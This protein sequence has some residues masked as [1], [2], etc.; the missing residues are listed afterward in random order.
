MGRHHPGFKVVRQDSE[1]YGQADE[2]QDESDPGE[3]LDRVVVPETSCYCF[4]CRGGVPEEARDQSRVPIPPPELHRHLDERQVLVHRLD[5][6]LLHV[7]VVA[8]EVHPAGGVAGEGT[9]TC[10]GIPDRP[11]GH[12]TGHPGG[13]F[14]APDLPAGHVVEGVDLAVADDDI[15]L[16]VEDGPEE[17]RDLSSVVLEVGVGVD[18]DIRPEFYGGIQ[19]VPEGLCEPEVP[20]VGDDVV[21]A[22]VQC[23]FHRVVGRAVIDDEYLDPVDPVHGAG[24]LP[25]DITDGVFFIVCGDCYDEF[26]A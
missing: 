25:D 9:K 2:Y 19:A 23:G 10:L 16:P 21:G 18:D 4:A 15:G 6:G 11:A 26:H 22:G 7:G 5:E 14:V 12:P 24:D 3:D 8:G 20:L 13:E 17:L 1:T